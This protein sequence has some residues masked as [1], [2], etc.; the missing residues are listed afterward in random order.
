MMELHHKNKNVTNHSGSD[1]DIPICKNY[2]KIIRLLY[3]R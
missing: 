1:Y 2:N 3:R